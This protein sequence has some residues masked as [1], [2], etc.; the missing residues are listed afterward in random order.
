M[1]PLPSPDSDEVLPFR[2]ARSARRG[3][4]SNATDGF[5]EAPLPLDEHDTGLALRLCKGPRSRHV[6][7]P[8]DLGLRR[9][10]P[11]AKG[12]IIGYHSR[13]PRSEII[14]WTEGLS[15]IE[16]WLPLTSITSAAGHHRLIFDRLVPV[17][18]ARYRIRCRSYTSIFWL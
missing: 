3:Q 7:F 4:P 8:A 1:R 10:P 9:A 17:P 2:Q 16:R 11:N 14:A 6:Q 12:R 18:V 5:D 15:S 13:F